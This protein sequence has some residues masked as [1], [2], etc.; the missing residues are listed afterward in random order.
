MT[1]GIKTN[2]RLQSLSGREGGTIRTEQNGPLFS[3]IIPGFLT[4]AV[5]CLRP[6]FSTGFPWLNCFLENSNSLVERL[7]S[8]CIDQSSQFLMLEWLHCPLLNHWMLPRHS[9]ALSFKKKAHWGDWLIGARHLKQLPTS[10]HSSFGQVL[11]LMG[12]PANG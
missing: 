7:I 6:S 3:L 4:W 1:R 10:S 9:R 2:I 5:R 12:E 11:G 8:F